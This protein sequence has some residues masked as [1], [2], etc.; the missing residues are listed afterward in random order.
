MTIRSIIPGLIVAAICTACIEAPTRPEVGTP[1]PGAPNFAVDYGLSPDS[2]FGVNANTLWSYASGPL[3]MDYVRDAGIS[4]VRVDVTW[5]NIQPSSSTQWDWSSTDST[6]AWVTQRNINVLG[7]LQ[8]TPGWANG[9]QHYTYPPTDDHLPDWQAFVATVARRYP[10]V[11]Y[12]SIWNEPN[13]PDFFNGD[14]LNYATLV[15]YAAGELHH[16]DVNAKVVA[17]EVAMDAS[18]CEQTEPWLANAI[19]KVWPSDAIDVVSMHVYGTAADIANSVNNFPGSVGP[20]VTGGWRWAL[21][22]TETGMGVQYSPESTHEQNKADHLRDVMAEMQSQSA[23]E[24]WEKTFY[25]HLYTKA[26]WDA[27]ILEGYETNPND[28]TAV[29]P[30]PAHAAYKRV[31]TGCP[32]CVAVHRLYNGNY[33]GEP[34]HMDSRDPAEGAAEG[35]SLEDRHSFWLPSS[36]PG[37]GYVALY[38]CWVDWHHYVS[39][40]ASCEVGVPAEHLVGYVA[41]TQ[42]V[43]LMRA[44]HRLRDPSTGDR[45]TTV[46]LAEVAY[47]TEAVGWVN[48]GILGYVYP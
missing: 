38:R 24:W 32:N 35:Y 19:N 34:D 2:P 4:W 44:L 17:G 42:Q 39:T 28:T 12:W 23:T 9:N 14:Y 45:L 41:S 36:S 30:E 18:V 7:V 8:Y 13:C 26:G 22:L 5:S 33:F 21:W 25:W 31:T 15:S 43:E 37:G 29:Y 40:D 27:A 11:K 16:P 6:I 10:E 46:D 20:L 3:L 48:E 1:S 47:Y